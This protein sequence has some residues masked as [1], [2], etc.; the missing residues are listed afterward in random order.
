MLEILVDTRRDDAD[1]LGAAENSKKW[2]GDIV[3]AKISG[4]DDRDWGSIPPKRWLITLLNDPVLEAQL[5]PGELI[6]NPYS[7]YEEH[8]WTTEQWALFTRQE[9]ISAL[10]TY[11]ETPVSEVAELL[12][13]VDT[14]G[15]GHPPETVEIVCRSYYQ[16]DLSLFSD[17]P[18]LDPDVSC[19]LCLPIGKTH[20]ELSDLILDDSERP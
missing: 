3:Q 7:C 15:I 10:A 19:E 18:G 8:G 4:S 13:G 12:R 1:E 14:A 17:T 6:S 5:N 20:L 9:R 11:L 16:V 2:L